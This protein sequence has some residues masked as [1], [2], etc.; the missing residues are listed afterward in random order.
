MNYAKITKY[1]IANGDGVR[2]VLWV[3]GCDHCCDEC[4]NPETW[5][6]N[7]GNKFT[8]DTVNEI[9]NSLNHDYISGLT[10][11]G[12]D[13]LKKENIPELTRL[14]KLAKEKFPQK[15]IWCWTGYEYE[16]VMNRSD[17]QEIIKYID[18]LVDG[19][20]IKSQHDI[21][22]KW[23]GSRNQRVIDLKETL[24]DGLVKLYCE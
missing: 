10:L 24:R 5:D 15:D 11:S 1:D 9:L 14:V 2:V 4:Q 16:E 6:S 8:N 19:E 17:T 20:Y 13:P 23:R 7:Y 12:G 22:L 21:T 3:S 18:V